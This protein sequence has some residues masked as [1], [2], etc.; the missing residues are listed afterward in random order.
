MPTDRVIDAALAIVDDEG[1]QALSMRLLAQR[2]DSGTATLYRHFANRG[3]V[4]DHVVD[5]VF[6]EVVIDIADHRGDA[7][8]QGCRAVAEMMYASLRRHR[9]VA[10]LLVD[11][12]PRGPSAMAIREFVVATLLE[13]GFPPELAARCYATLARHVLG[14]SIQLADAT[15]DDDAV[16]QALRNADAQ[17]FPATS[18]VASYLPVAL[19][20]EFTFGLELL[21]TGFA[22]TYSRTR[23]AGR[24]Q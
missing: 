7:W 23:G 1:A 11:R 12:V 3:E 24:G 21:L 4:L 10:A 20:D 8:Q 16:R 13:N 22:Q 19:D 2:L 6:A 18:R 15:E 14:F 9:N 5:R 17:R